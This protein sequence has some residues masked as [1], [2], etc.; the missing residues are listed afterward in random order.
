MDSFEIDAKRRQ[1]LLG[2][3][4]AGSGLILP[5]DF[6]RAQGSASDDVL[7]IAYISDVPTWDPTAITVP[8]AQ[9]IYE[10]VFDSPLRYSPTLKLE[11]RQIT[12]WKW[13]D[14]TDQRLEVT[15]R[16]DILFHD[17]S[18]LT[19][20]DL[21]YS[22]HDRPSADKKLAV[23]GMFQTLKDVEIISPTRAVLVYSKPTPAAPIYLAFLAGY[24]L[25]KA[26]MEKVGIDGFL[27]KPIGAGPYKLVDYQRGSRIVLE[28]FDKYWGGVPA[29]K[30]V[31]FQIT[32]EPSARVAAVESGRAG[33][34]VQ[35]PLREAQRLAKTPGIT[36]KIYPYSEIYMLRMPNYVKPFD[37]ENVR[38]A[39]HYAID[40]AA[41]SKAFYGGEAVPLSVT[42]T[43]GSP[44]DVPGF[45]IGF[46]PQRAIAALAKSG[47]GPNKPVKVPFLTTNGTFPSDYDMARAI[48]G[49]W[50]RVGIQADL[51]QTTMAKV[52]GEIQ[53]TKMSGVLLY[54]WANSTGDPENYTGRILDPRL[55]FSA[56][57][58]D[59]L[60]PRVEA[61]M[62]EVDE[63]KRMAG[64]RALSQ[65]ASEKSWVV[66]LLQAVTTIAYRSNIDVKTFDSGYILPVEYKRK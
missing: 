20:A 57:K 53:A 11:A 8:Q 17:G 39:M 5:W 43:P 36:T 25:P 51:T 66:P 33:V 4:A 15:L 31:T 55:R 65:E 41:L 16:D 42:A 24:I 59:A 44:A 60:A 2:S 48:A 40:T 52:I 64:Y 22:L 35:I 54:S 38:A 18:K 32:T 7:N 29:I 30:N 37:D 1:W 45:K 28:G 50:Q 46:D 14:K 21:K 49:M 19:T 61:L 56:W 6:A 12:A 26:Y 10:T 62:T 47:Y 27:A 23:G 63:E 58:D 9:S 34:A 13:Q 3:L